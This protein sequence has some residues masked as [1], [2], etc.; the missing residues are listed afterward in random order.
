MADIVFILVALAFFALCV[1]YTRGL[2][3]LV[4]SSEE[5]EAAQEATS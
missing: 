1:A 3:R 4:R 2:D 5:G